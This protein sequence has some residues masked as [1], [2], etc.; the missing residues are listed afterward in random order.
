MLLNAAYPI[1]WLIAIFDAIGALSCDIRSC[2][3]ISSRDLTSIASWT[4]SSAKANLSGY[5]GG[6]CAWWF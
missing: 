5:G 2:G 3:L 1:Q 4:R 6:V